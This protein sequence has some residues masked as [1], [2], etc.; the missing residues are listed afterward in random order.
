MKACPRIVAPFSGFCSAP[1]RKVRKLAYMY[2]SCRLNG[3]GLALAIPLLFGQSYVFAQYQT[4]SYPESIESSKASDRLRRIEVIGGPYLPQAE[5]VSGQGRIVIYRGHDGQSGAASVFVGGRYHASLVPGAW[6]RLCFSTGSVGVAARHVEATLRPA[7]DSIDDHL[8]IEVQSRQIHYLRVTVEREGARLRAVAVPEAINDIR[9]AREQ[10]HTISRVGLD[11]ADAVPAGVLPED[12]RGTHSPPD[13]PLAMPAQHLGVD[14][15]APARMA[16][17][18]TLSA[19]S[20]F[21]FGRSDRAGMT[22][23]GVRAIDLLLERVAKEYSRVDHLHLVGHADPLGLATRNEILS[24]ERARAVRD[25]INTTGLLRAPMSAEGK[26]STE[27]V[28]RDCGRRPTPESIACNQPNRRV[29]L[30]VYG[31]LRR[32]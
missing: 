27:P 2:L 32:I 23:S 20:L 5:P 1:S 11:C 18:F 3:A 7:K 22:D 14:A 26:G 8:V 15:E 6:S 31:V 17:T 28:V 24:V 10:R 29:T 12:L 30:Q 25:Y 13:Q 21:A 9:T 19:D 16:R 4:E